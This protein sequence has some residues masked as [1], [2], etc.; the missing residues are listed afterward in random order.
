MHEFAKIKPKKGPEAEIQEAICKFLR[1]RSWYVEETHGNMYQNGWPDLFA[2]HIHYGFRFIEVKNPLSY[3]FTPAQ[4][5]KFPL[6]CANGAGIWI[7]A[8]ATEEE[9]A[10]LNK[11]HNWQYYHIQLLLKQKRIS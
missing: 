9:Y 6:F 3:S 4:L 1:A 2:T 8:A 5:E 10:K 11:P 7:M